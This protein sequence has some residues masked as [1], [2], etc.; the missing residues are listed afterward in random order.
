MHTYGFSVTIIGVRIKAA[1]G[2]RSL[3]T[4]ELFLE[5]GASR[6]GASP[7]VKL[8]KNMEAQGY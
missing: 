1:G 3:E 7:I 5:I 6:L 4:A 2:I 8:T